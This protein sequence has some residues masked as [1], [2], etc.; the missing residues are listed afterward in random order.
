MKQ[1]SLLTKG[2]L[3]VLVMFGSAIPVFAEPASQPYGPQEQVV[4]D[5]EDEFTQDVSATGMT[6][7]Q[8]TTDMSKDLI[9]HQSTNTPVVDWEDEF[10]YAVQLK[11]TTQDN[12]VMVKR[13]NAASWDHEA[14]QAM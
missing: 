4:I 1:Q 12:K 9:L 13:E 6:A 10:F 3:A 2:V 7:E 14:W 11:G 5:W 8:K